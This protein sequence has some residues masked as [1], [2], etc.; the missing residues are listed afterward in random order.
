M[1]KV[2][3]QSNPSSSLN[4]I[5]LVSGGKDSFLSLLHCF[6]QGHNVVALANLYPPAFDGPASDLNSHMYQT[7]GYTLVEL[8]SRIL[9][10]PL[11]RGAIT[12]T[13]ISKEKEY[14]QRDLDLKE[15]TEDLTSLLNRVK[16]YH[17]EANALSSGAI[18][19]TYQRTR[20][21]SICSRLGLTS[22]A[23]LWQWPS[24]PSSTGAPGALLEDASN[25]GLDAR[26]VKVASGGLDDTFLWESLADARVRTRVEKAVGRFGGSVLGEGGEFETIV[27]NGPTGLWKGRIEVDPRNRIV[28]RGDGGEAWLEFVNGSV[29][30]NEAGDDGKEEESW[31]KRLRIPGLWDGDFEKILNE[32]T[33]IELLQL[34]GETKPEVQWSGQTH[35]RDHGSTFSLSNVTSPADGDALKDQMAYIN[36]SIFTCL[37]A[38]N[39]DPSN[40]IFTTIL[41]RSMSDFSVVNSIYGQLFTAPNPPARVTIACGARMPAKKQVMVSILA[42]KGPKEERRGLHVQSRSYWAPANIG[43]YSQAISV[44]PESKP[45]DSLSKIVHVAGQIPLVPSTMEAL[46]G[47]KSETQERLF[48]KQTLLSLQHLWRIGREMDVNWWSGGIAFL[49]GTG[50]VDSDAVTMR[51]QIAWSLWERLHKLPPKE[52]NEDDDSEDVSGPDVWDLKY[53]G[54]GNFANEAAQKRPLP[55]FANVQLENP[56]STDRRSDSNPPEYITP[57]FFAVEITELPRLSS[58]EWQATGYSGNNFE[59]CNG[60]ANDVR[61]NPS[62]DWM[63][64]TSTLYHSNESASPS[65][66][67]TPPHSTST[68]FLSIPLR[69]TLEFLLPDSLGEG[70]TVEPLVSVY[71]PYPDLFLSFPY[72]VIP[73]SRIWAV[74]D[75][76]LEEI[77][78]GLTITRIISE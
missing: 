17:P 77:G 64:T 78:A 76:R 18:L 32:D 8:Y 40:I 5:A 7:A 66:K 12:G 4:V 10:I 20:V 67:D 15:E 34:D 27:V 51:A 9:S 43:P 21:E 49:A 25:V 36:A 55:D 59:L 16:R 46:A 68:S 28:R 37:E 2:I 31:K 61:P 62:G 33:A 72:Q 70:G 30:N 50:I 42:H 24:L 65:L 73:C 35:C 75:G 45:S 63:K 26:I 41:L 54:M 56:P 74:R 58:I 47:E 22:L 52:D 69:Q 53:G 71:S 44:N 38:R 60:D 6:A 19:S 48:R 57:G 13:A 39:A 3:T 23:F 29:V 14:M 1:A 11:Y